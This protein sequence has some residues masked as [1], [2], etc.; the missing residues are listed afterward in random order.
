MLRDAERNAPGVSTLPVRAAVVLA[1]AGAGFDLVRGQHQPERRLGL[2][3]D[4][5]LGGEAFYNL[6]V[7]P[8]LRVTLDAQVIDP[9]LRAS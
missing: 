7:T 2:G 1:V 9:A 3:V 4:N 6:A 8:W 5:E